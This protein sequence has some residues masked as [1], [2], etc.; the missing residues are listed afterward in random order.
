MAGEV[1]GDLK[2]VIGFWGGTALIIGITI[3]SGIFRKPGT[4]AG[5][6]P[7]PWVILGLWTSLGAICISGALAV[8]ELSSMLPKTGGSYVFLRAAY[9]DSSAFVFGW[10]YLLVTAP[11]GIGAL[12]T[13]F[14]ELLLLVFGAQPKDAPSWFTPFVAGG[15][16][17]WFSV[18]NLMGTRGGSAIQGLLTTIKV[19][20]LL[21]LMVIAVVLSHGSLNHF[22]GGEPVQM[23]RLGG[24]IAGVIWAYDGWIA[25]SMIA[26][27]VVAPEKLL[28]RIIVFGMAAIV[29][30]YVGANVAYLYAMPLDAMAAQKEFVPQKIVSDAL[31]PGMGTAI[32][33][34]IMCSVLG[35][36]SGNV[37]AKP[38]VS[39]ALAQDGLTFRFLGKA[40]PRW[41]SPY[42]AILIQ[43]VVAVILVLCLK[44]FDI[45]TT[46]F[47]VV[48]WF[49]LLFT[50]GAVF[51][52]R[53]RMPDTPRPFRTPGYPWLPLIFVVGT[54]VGLAAIV[55]TELTNT[56]TVG[57]Q[58]V[59]D[60]HYSPLWGL[61]IAVAGFPVFWIWRR[62]ARPQTAPSA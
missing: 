31:G 20:A 4:L 10:L 27:E 30:L 29:F 34:C 8:A 49:A 22:G 44:D 1:K 48:E 21:A 55:W 38:R 53:R 17:V 43:A 16:I 46:Y 7:N 23:N 3:G 12:A 51:V 60:P 13:F 45:I 32:S 6:L 61:L 41:S 54:A 59:P 26:G 62:L 19:G 37:L 52:L 39:Y 40:H 56:K 5:A 18:V 25:V 9:G 50:V 14:V 11:A 42:A 36:L 2:R 35:A 47:V 33:A 15:M 28:K 57:D 24:G 58:V